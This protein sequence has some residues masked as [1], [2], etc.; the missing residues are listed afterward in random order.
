MMKFAD[1]LLQ[2]RQFFIEA[3]VVVTTILLVSLLAPSLQTSRVRIA[4]QAQSSSANQAVSSNYDSPNAMT[5][6]LFQ[7][8][9]DV[10]QGSHVIGL[11][12]LS[13]IV[14]TAAA[15]ARFDKDI[16]R[17]ARTATVFTL[18][19]IGKS[20][21]FT[22][23]GIGTGATFTFRVVGKGLSST[24]HG[25]GFGFSFMGHE[26]GNGFGFFS[27]LTHASSLIRPQDHSRVPTITQA[28][29]EQA[30]IIQSGTEGV[31]LP[32]V[33]NG[34]GGACDSGE[35][36][37]DYPLGWCSAPMDSLPTISYSSDKINRECT[38]YA[39]W[40]FT[41]IEGHADFRAS[42]NA[43]YWANTSNYPTHVVPAVGAIA[44]E[45]A[46]AYGHVAIVQAL[47]GQEFAGRVVPAGYVLVSEMN[48]DWN[49]HFRYSYSPLGKFSAYIY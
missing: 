41:A 4:A 33:S 23:R 11:K 40:Y 20:V 1:I 5:S 16:V 25:I 15:A 7:M 10:E 18:R 36:N 14:A 37:G 17:G 45:T 29:A 46:G 44:V 22:F 6:M 38:S 2:K 43:K 32:A 28:R 21:A 3:V 8:M 42:G 9:G 24:A 19:G 48:Y 26:I 47:S 27:R 49:G 12:V 39:Y 13:S 35:G 30:S 34:A 31:A